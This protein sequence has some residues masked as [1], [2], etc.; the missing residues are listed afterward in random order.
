MTATATTTARVPFGALLRVNLIAAVL[1]AA[2]TEALTAVVRAAGV[3]LAVGDP[4][5]S[6]DSVVPVAAGAC[7]LSVA[8]CMV[9]GIAIA[10]LVNRFAARPARTYRITTGVLVLLSLAAP[11]TAVATSTPTRL[12]LVAAHLVAGAIVVT[13]VGRRLAGAR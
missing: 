9:V 8:T 5:G 3:D 7:A 11:L 2:A 12:T 6:P 4:G 13:M 10:A 1:A